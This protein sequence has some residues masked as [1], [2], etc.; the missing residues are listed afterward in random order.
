MIDAT[1][2]DGA[3]VDSTAMDGRA[4]DGR[5]IDGR[6]VDGRG[7]DG[8]GIDGRGI[9]GRGIAGIGPL[10]PLVAIAHGS[11]DP[12]AGAAVAELLNRVHSRAARHGLRGLEVVTAYLD[13]APPS[14][15]QVL[16]ALYGTPARAMSVS[17]PAGGS[18][19]RALSANAGAM[20]G[21]QGP[22]RR[23]WYEGNA[24]SQASTVVALPLL[25]TDAYHS[26]TDIPSVLHA[27]AA[28]LPGLRIRYAET[29][30][31]HPLLIGAMERRLSEAGVRIGDPDTAVVL[32]SAGSSDP[33]AREVI[34]ALARDWQ[35]LRGWREVVPAFAS[36]ASPSPAGAVTALRRSGASRVVVATY[37]LAPGVFADKVRES[38]RAAGATAVSAV[39][40]AAPELA[41]LVV[42][43]YAAASAGIV[44]PEMAATG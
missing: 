3:G 40:G 36:A 20:P 8:R 7:I 19:P 4:I 29:L 22:S 23:F 13:H 26:K 37:L 27:A 31:P 15:A 17:A 1:S 28:A 35:A 6:A 11:R 33:A 30:G 16:S 12:R 5:G 24:A 34:A 32:A 9:D 2:I 21:E 18:L 41:D 43:R 10:P 25:L 38:S 14:P 39:L 44:R 42:R